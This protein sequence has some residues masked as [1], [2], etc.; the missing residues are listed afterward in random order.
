MCVNED[1]DSL[2]KL[3]TKEEKIFDDVRIAFLVTATGKIVY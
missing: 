3:D 1:E 2:I